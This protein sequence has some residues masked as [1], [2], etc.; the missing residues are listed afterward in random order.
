MTYWWSGVQFL[1]SLVF[2]GNMIYFMLL[3][4]RKDK[5]LGHKTRCV[6]KEDINHPLIVTGDTDMDYVVDV[7]KMFYYIFFAGVFINL[8]QAIYSVCACF[9]AQNWK[10]CHQAFMV[11][12]YLA[13]L[14]YLSTVTYLRYDHAGRVCSGDYLFRPISNKTRESGVLGIEGQFLEVFIIAGWI[15]QAVLLTIFTTHACSGEKNEDR[16][17]DM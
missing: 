7:G 5:E 16:E 9:T 6:A 17:R 8:V 11:I 14:T 10:A 3:H 2:M 15:Q 12:M 1:V 4:Q 13:S